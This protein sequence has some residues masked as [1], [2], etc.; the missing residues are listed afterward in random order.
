MHLFSLNKVSWTEGGV[1]KCKFLVTKAVCEIFFWEINYFLYN[2]SCYFAKSCWNVTLR[3]LSGQLVLRDN[4]SPVLPTALQISTDHLFLMSTMKK[5]LKHPQR[6][7]FLNSV[8]NIS[9]T[10]LLESVST[11]KTVSVNVTKDHFTFSRCW[12][13]IQWETADAVVH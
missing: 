9:K 7:H 8:D 12:Q 3:Y 13:K 10:L 11:E 2:H 1:K 6:L 4:A 5:P